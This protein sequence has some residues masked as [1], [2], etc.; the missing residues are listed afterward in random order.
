MERFKIAILSR[1]P[2]TLSKQ[3]LIIFAESGGQ[4]LKTDSK[5]SGLNWLG[6]DGCIAGKF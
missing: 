3:L 5:I 1:K 2:Q 4:N 6:I